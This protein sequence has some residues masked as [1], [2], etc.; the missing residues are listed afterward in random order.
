MS[1]ATV[2]AVRRAPQHDARRIVCRSDTWEFLRDL[3]QTFGWHPRGTTYVTSARQNPSA[4]EP[5]RHNYQPGGMHDSKR[6]EAADATEWASA[7][8][9]AKRSPYFSGMM[10]AHIGLG[11]SSEQSL[12]NIL[13][14]FI[15]FAHDGAFVFSLCAEAELPTI[16]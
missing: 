3:G 13:D 10:R 9:V 6:I 5:I 12:L 15:Q 16:A 4:P 14:E 1:C 11:R 2:V 8:Q 7:L